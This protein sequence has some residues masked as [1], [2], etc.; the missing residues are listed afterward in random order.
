MRMNLKHLKSNPPW[1]TDVIAKSYKAIEAQVPAVF[2]PQFS[3]VKTSQDRILA[4]IDE[5]GCGVFGCV[6]PTLDPNVV[7]KVTTDQTEAEFA[8]KLANGL[9]AD[10]C[11]KYH[12]IMTT[13]QEHDGRVIHLLWRDAA[14]FVGEIDEVD[15]D[16]AAIFVGRQHKAAQLAYKAA[17]TGDMRNLKK[18]ID[19]WV[20]SCAVMADQN[21]VLS[22]KPLGAGLVKVWDEQRVLFGDIHGGNLG[23]VADR[24]VITD[25][26]NIAVVKYDTLVDAPEIDDDGPLAENVI[27]QAVPAG[28]A[29]RVRSRL[30]R[31]GIKMMPVGDVED[32]LNRAMPEG[33][34]YAGLNFAQAL[35]L[36]SGVPPIGAQPN[37]IYVA[38]PSD[39][40]DHGVYG[41]DLDDSKM[42]KV[43]KVWKRGGQ[44]GAISVHVD[45][46]GDLYL[47]DGGAGNEALQLS[48]TEN[49]PVALLVKSNEG[50]LKRADAVEIS[51]RL[52][53]VIP[54]ETAK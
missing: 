15:G 46:I 18:F 24:W 42:K 27:I 22:I 31:L 6:L 21:D 39:I 20:T 47:W 16:R 45:S 2:L 25:P 3:E 23:I 29:F 28:D 12:Y 35:S 43:T 49:E 44:V 40:A 52:Y 32:L 30:I 13:Q 53:R 38:R 33:Y 11:V 10:I 7:L 37:N 9:V 50:W 51:D 14:S 19:A 17:A 1:V 34:T 4:R 5:F 41:I 54:A 26:G 36:R 48:A 8:A